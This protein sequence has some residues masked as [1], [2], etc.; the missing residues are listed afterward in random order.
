MCVSHRDSS[1]TSSFLFILHE[2]MQLENISLPASSYLLAT[3]DKNIKCFSNRIICIEMSLVVIAQFVD[4]QT[5]ARLKIRMGPME[6]LVRKRESQELLSSIH[7]DFK[8]H[9]IMLQY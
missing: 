2:N 1:N 9:I 8:K 4:N 7:W 5:C 6:Q 3:I